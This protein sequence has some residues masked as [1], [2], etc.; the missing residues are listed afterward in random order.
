MRK[1]QP[2]T[3]KTKYEIER[4]KINEKLLHFA[5]IHRVNK[6]W[7][8]SVFTILI[9]IVFA[10]LGIIFVQNTGIYGYGVDAVCHG[11]ARFSAGLV[12]KYTYNSALAEKLFIILFWLVNMLLNIPLLILASYK[13]NKKFS[14][15]T[16]LF[17]LFITVFGIGFSFIPGVTNIQIMGSALSKDFVEK[18]HNVVQI[19]TWSKPDD[20]GKHLAIVMYGLIWALIQGIA[21]ALLLILDSS[22][23][24]FDILVVWYA[25]KKFQNLSGMFAI[26]HV[27]SLLFGNFLGTYIPASLYA[28]QVDMKPWTAELFFNPN[29]CSSLIMILIN[30]LVVDVIF[31]KYKM[32]KIEIY[33]NKYKEILSEIYSLKDKRFAA[34]VGTVKGGYS[35]QE[36]QSVIVNCFYVD[37]PI[38]INIV[39]KVDEGALITIYDIKKMLGHV[40]ITKE[41]NE[42]RTP[43]TK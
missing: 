40:Y 22:T 13:I 31:P 32:V 2:N 21:A 29:F 34:S 36:Q 3:P 35:G 14:I 4:V 12:D 43:K 11:I 39:N 7:H 8:Q 18:S 27:F 33:S 9:A 42:V 16:T 6:F 17:L 5:S 41:M 28:S 23:A 24:G 25:R 15:L 37:A 26:F 10:F 19:A 38:I 30:G 1:K 20:A